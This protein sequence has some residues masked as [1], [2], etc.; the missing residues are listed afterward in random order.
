MK[1]GVKRLESIL[2]ALAVIAPVKLLAGLN[3]EEYLAG[4]DHELA[5]AAGERHLLGRLLHQNAPAPDGKVENMYPERRGVGSAQEDSSTTAFTQR[6]EDADL[7]LQRRQSGTTQ[8]AGDFSLGNILVSSG[9][10]TRAQVDEA[11][12]RQT[13]SGRRLGEELIHAGHAVRSEVE[14]GLR[15]QRHLIT[16]ALVVVAGLAPLATATAYAGQK[17]ATLLVS[18]TVIANARVRTDYQATQLSISTTD[19]ARGYVEIAAASRF[20]VFTNSRSGYLLEFFPVG[21]LFES[22][23]VKGL[24]NDVQLGADGG[25]IV[26]R[27]Q[28]PPNR[29]HELSFRFSLSP[30]TQPG[31]YP[32][33]LL[34]SVRPL[35]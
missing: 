29:I 23:Q 25:A 33:P 1:T 7:A 12:S 3:I 17:S 34:L 16:Y 15:L 21:N 6:K 19:V 8:P 5:W 35:S 26:Q 22:V 4:L 27:G 14:A 20:S 2:S 31:N 10:T 28:L 18:A 24:G 13:T 30:G 9:Q 32:W 11:L